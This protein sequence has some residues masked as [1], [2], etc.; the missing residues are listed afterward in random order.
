[1]PRG[2]S[3]APRNRFLVRAIIRAREIDQLTWREIGKKFDLSP[4][5]VWTYYHRWNSW[6][7]AKVEASPHV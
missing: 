2:L 6:A 7:K 1:M 3:I 5:A 4:N